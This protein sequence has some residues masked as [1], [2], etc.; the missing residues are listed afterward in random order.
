MHQM[1]RWIALALSLVL[2]SGCDGEEP[3]DAGPPDAGGL[4][5]GFDAGAPDAGIDAGD[6]RPPAPATLSE[7]GLF[8]SGASG[9][10]A[11]DVLSYDVRYPLW[12]DDLEKRRHLVLPA[13]TSIDVSDPDQWAFPAG[14]RVFKEFILEGQP[15]ETRMFWK[16]GPSISDWVYVSY[17]YR[18]D[19][20]DADPMPDGV[21]DALGTFHDVPDTGACFNCHRGGGD[22]ILGIGALQL[23]RATYDAWVASGVLPSDAAFGEPPGDAR[24]QAALGYMHGN[25]GHCHGELHP[26]AANRSLRL[27]LPV[28]VTD[29]FMAPAWVTAAWEPANHTIGGTTRIVV[30]GDPE[31]SQLYVRMGLR[32]EEAMP[33]FGTELVDDAGRAAVAAWIT[34]PP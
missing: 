18:P 10:Y 7:T 30:P 23:A 28:G 5:A 16:T 22:L 31:M 17:V 29:P 1:N 14:T 13:G 34:G 20:S 21:V 6:P 4:D 25:C 15:I 33:P 9:P 19:G 11:A 32:D 3:A 8:E 27:R 12:T 26:L 2:A 24:E